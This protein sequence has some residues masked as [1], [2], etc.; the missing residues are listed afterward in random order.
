MK[1]PNNRHYNLATYPLEKLLEELSEKIK[2]LTLL[3]KASQS[4]FWRTIAIIVALATVVS[5]F[6]EALSYFRG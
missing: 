5:A 4:R 1:N 2:E 3:Y 6:F